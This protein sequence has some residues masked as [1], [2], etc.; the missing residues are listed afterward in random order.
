MEIRF[1]K[2]VS[3]KKDCWKIKQFLFLSSQTQ[4]LINQLSYYYYLK[5]S[6]WFTWSTVA[7]ITSLDLILF[8][9]FHKSFDLRRLLKQAGYNVP[10]WNSY[11]NLVIKYAEKLHKK[12]AIK[13]VNVMTSDG[14]FSVT[15]DEWTLCWN[16]RYSNLSLHSNQ[17]QFWN[18][19]VIR[20]VGCMTTEKCIEIAK[21]RLEYFQ[22]HFDRIVGITTNFLA[23]MVKIIKLLE[24][25]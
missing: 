1:T 25:N 6:L 23:V 18:L 19:G 2:C 3:S 21:R 15:F 17:N 16:W 4:V 7:C 14:T 5:K 24:L 9:K 8:I 22:V 12:F 10:K 13:L 20:I 11:K